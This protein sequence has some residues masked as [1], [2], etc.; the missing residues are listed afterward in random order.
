MFLIKLLSIK[1][2]C[3]ITLQKML[4]YRIRHIWFNLDCLCWFG[5]D[6]NSQIVRIFQIIKMFVE[7]F[8]KIVMFLI[9]FPVFVK[10][11]FRIIFSRFIFSNECSRIIFDFVIWIFINIVFT[12]AYFLM[13]IILIIVGYWWIYFGFTSFSFIFSI[14]FVIS[15]LIIVITNY[16]F[17]FYIWI[18]RFCYFL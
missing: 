1:K 13:R 7:F 17:L 5:F 6:Q 10:C 15:I 18:D 11:K 14:N 3:I 16:W 4:N 8:S 2:P 12:Y 9:M